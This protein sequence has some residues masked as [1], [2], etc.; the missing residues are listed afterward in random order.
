MSLGM[1][2]GGRLGLFEELPK[3]S[4]FVELESPILGAGE[5]AALFDVPFLKNRV[6]RI[7]VLV[8]A[9][10]GP[11]GLE[12][13]VKD[14]AQRAQAVLR[15]RHDKDVDRGLAAGVTRRRRSG[16]RPGPTGPRSG[17]CRPRFGP[18]A[19]GRAARTR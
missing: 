6:V 7:S 9:A 3:T 1:Y 13:A 16:G 5:I 4:G 14:I 2:L 19:G 17:P 8:D 15:I 11:E 18:Q 10:L 12:R